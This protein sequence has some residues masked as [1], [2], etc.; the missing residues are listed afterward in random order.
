MLLVMS[1]FNKIKEAIDN[2][3][4]IKPLDLKKH[5]QKHNELTEELLEVER[6]YIFKDQAEEI[7]YYKMEKPEF[8]KY[9]I[10]IDRVYDMYLD[11]PFGFKETKM[12]FLQQEMNKLCTFQE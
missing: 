7:R 6:T 8:M 12:E 5:H 9:G 1:K 11:E 3:L 2:G 10:F 4:K